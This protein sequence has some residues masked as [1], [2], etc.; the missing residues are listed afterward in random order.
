M[1]T[2]RILSVTILVA[3]MA[4]PAAAWGP[5][6]RKAV[7]SAAARTIAQEGTAPLNKLMSDV[8]AG[9]QAPAEE[10]DALYPGLV[11][12]PVRAVQSEM[13]LLDTMRGKSLDPYYAYRLGMLGALVARVSAPLAD[14]P[15]SIRDRYYADVDAVVEQTALRVTTRK[16]VDPEAYFKRVQGLANA[17][18]DLIVKDYQEGSG[19]TNV[20]KGSVTEDIGRSVEAVADV[21]S[22]ILTRKVVH[23]SV[24]PEQV[25]GYVVGA[26]RYYVARG[27]EREVATNLERLTEGREQSAKM[28]KQIGD[29][30]YD[31]GF[32]ERAIEEYRIVLRVE[33]G[34]KDVVSRIASYYVKVGDEALA[35]K[36]LQ[37]A[38]DAYA[39]A[40]KTDPLHPAAEAR[41]L[42]AQAQIAAREARLQAV[43]GLI[44]EAAS[45]QEQADTFAEQRKFGEAITALSKAMVNYGNV[46]D[47][48]PPERMAANA[49]RASV[50]ARLTGLQTQLVQNSQS[51]SGAGFAV[52]ARQMAAAQTKEFDTQALK[53]M[54]AKQLADETERLRTKYG[55]AIA[56]K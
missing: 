40:A 8:M 11:T 21:W 29:A 36:R 2:I 13:D 55:N 4:W 31:G 37:D 22:T 43:R 3:C 9:V 27:N 56:F 53:S 42:E 33:P 16:K 32:Y 46:T 48:F 44:E 45:L 28:A 38:L 39:M 25:D 6:T 50:T 1:K 54:Q 51:L 23:A 47:E 5:A 17:R 26:V 52:S 30:L 18:K 20:A 34:T 15:P 14:A 10:V 7:V 24:S 19:F 12:A 35:K 49:G 41:R